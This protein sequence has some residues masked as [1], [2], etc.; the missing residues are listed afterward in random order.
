VSRFWYIIR[1]SAENA[2]RFE[3]RVAMEA[4]AKKT[5]EVARLR[6]NAA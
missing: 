6:D 3:D 4:E 2:D 5:P 1:G